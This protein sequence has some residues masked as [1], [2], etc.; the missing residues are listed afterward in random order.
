M[1]HSIA[2]KLAEIIQTKKTRL[3]V[4]ADLPKAQDILNLIDDVAEH[5]CIL[6]THVDIIE[7]FSWNFIEAMR[8]RARAHNFLI[9]EDRKFAD[10]GNT[11]R[12]QAGVGMYKIFEWADIVNAHILPGEGVIEGLK[13]AA[14]GKDVGLLLIAQMSSRGNFITPEYSLK[15][16]EL[17]K[18]HSDFVI[19]FIG[20]GSHPEQ[21][22]ELRTLCGN[23]FLI[24]TPGIKFAETHDDLG[25]AYATPKQA[26]LAGADVV[27]V[28]RGIYESKNRKESAGKYREDA[29]VVD[30]FGNDTI[31]IV[32][33]NT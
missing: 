10:I 32:E 33:V 28:G 22:K 9:F 11:V 13:E 16:V 12:L 31:K 19:G 1:K 21:I 23:E 3:C 5:I 18:K 26:L 29:M 20:S 27:I 7:D 14:R 30:T 6:K 8:E 15:T 2:Q 17:A 25:Q 4:A 24:L